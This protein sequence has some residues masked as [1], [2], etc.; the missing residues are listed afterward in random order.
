VV[1]FQNV[2]G[3]INIKHSIYIYIIR[4]ILFEHKFPLTVTCNRTHVKLINIR[5]ENRTRRTRENHKEKPKQNINRLTC[6]KNAATYFNIICKQIIL[7][8]S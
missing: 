8:L 2:G 4:F 5:N 3:S 1:L 7:I 6:E